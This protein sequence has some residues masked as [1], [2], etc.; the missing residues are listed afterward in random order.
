[1]RAWARA[2][3]R[4]AWG[5]QRSP[6]ARGG[7][8]TPPA[9]SPPTSGGDELVPLA[10]HIPTLVHQGIPTSHLAHPLPEGAAVALLAGLLHQVPVG[11]LDVVLGGLAV[12]PVA[13]FVV[14]QEL[15]GRV[16]HRA[17]V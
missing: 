17:V 4:A 7:A 1:E 11:I 8:K 10:D 14:G 15:L 9:G 16:G 5:S 3:R 6:R 13:P 2:A 12:V